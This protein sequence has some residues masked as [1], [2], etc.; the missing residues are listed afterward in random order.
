MS[1]LWFIG[2]NSYNECYIPDAEDTDVHQEENIYAR[3]ELTLCEWSQ[4][5]QVVDI[6]I[7]FRFNVYSLKTVRD[8]V[9]TF[10]F[11]RKIQSTQ[12]P[13]EV[14]NLCLLYFGDVLNEYWTAGDNFY[15]GCG[16]ETNFFCAYHFGD[17]CRSSSAPLSHVEGMD[18]VYNISSG[19][20][21]C[22]VLWIKNDGKLYV[23]GRNLWGQLGF[24]QSNADEEFEIGIFA[25][26]ISEFSVKHPDFKVIDGAS[27]ENWNIIICDDGTV[28]SAGRDI[29]SSHI[30]GFTLFLNSS[31]N[32]YHVVGVAAGDRHALFITESGAV[33]GCGENYYG[34]LGMGPGDDTQTP[35]KEPVLI[36]VF[37]EKEI[38]VRDICCGDSHS[39]ALTE[40]HQVFAWGHKDSE[41]NLV[42]IPRHIDALSDVV[43]INIKCGRNHSGCMSADKNVFLW[44]EN[45]LNQCCVKAKSNVNIPQCVNEYVMKETN[46]S[47]IIDFFLGCSTTMFLLK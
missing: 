35:Y 26:N 29:G 25:P 4:S 39:L 31:L 16:V 34:Q 19:C 11:I 44:G 24:Q 6:N 38:I 20:N 9:L 33:F 3:T 42:T 40:D 36:P 37:N 5:K 46:K 13:N 15:G 41:D 8:E 12:I 21:G 27:S 30:D 43:V 23:N 28:R 22:S 47:E 18:D 14:C 32:Q 17:G 7:G 1:T 2:Q 10:G 45:Q